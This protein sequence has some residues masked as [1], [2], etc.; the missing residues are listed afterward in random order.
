MPEKAYKKISPLTKQE[1]DKKKEMAIID[2]S[3]C[4]L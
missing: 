1:I 3:K 4:T 2:L